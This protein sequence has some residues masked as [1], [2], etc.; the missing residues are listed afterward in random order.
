MLITVRTRFHRIAVG[1]ALVFSIGLHWPILQSLAWM[2]M[3]VTYAQE[4]G[5]EVAVVKTFDGKNP[6]KLCH[7]VAE[8]QETEK[9]SSQDSILKKIDFVPAESTA[10]SVA[11]QLAADQTPFLPRSG[12]KQY[13]PLSPPP[14]QA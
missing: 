8:G 13:A 3:L 9:K 1:L 6:C 2:N 14:L 11:I 12:L 10:I 5:I 7:F 4:E